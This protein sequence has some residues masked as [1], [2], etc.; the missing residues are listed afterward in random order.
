M[1]IGLAATAAL[2]R[3]T[4]AVMVPALICRDSLC[5]KC[6]KSG[7]KAT[8]KYKRIGR[9]TLIGHGPNKPSDDGLWK[10]SG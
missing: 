1:R 10:P 6:Q 9:L 8:R 5:G 7:A 4:E 3:V 2:C